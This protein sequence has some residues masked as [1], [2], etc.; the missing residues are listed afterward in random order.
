MGAGERAPSARCLL[1][2]PWNPTLDL[3]D[4]QKNLVSA[5]AVSICLPRAGSGSRKQADSQTPLVRQPNQ[6]LISR[7]IERPGLKNKVGSNQDRHLMLTPTPM[8][9][10][11]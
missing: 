9:T 6:L 2:K 8:L 5:T 1:C 11:V 4:P 10:P 7:F 3:K